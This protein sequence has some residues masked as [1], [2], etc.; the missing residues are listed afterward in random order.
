MGALIYV[1]PLAALFELAPLGPWHWL[2]LASLGPLLLLLEELRKRPGKCCQRGAAAAAASVVDPGLTPRY[3]A[4][5]LR[6]APWR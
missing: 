2:L 4:S 5:N 3:L 1:P 6:A